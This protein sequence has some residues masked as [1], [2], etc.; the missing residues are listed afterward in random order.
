[1]HGV[2]QSNKPG[3]TQKSHSSPRV[4]DH[5]EKV[6]DMVCVELHLDEGMT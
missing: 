5:H 6:K 3:E 1:M 4:Q 2:T